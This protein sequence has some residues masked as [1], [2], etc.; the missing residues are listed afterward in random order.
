M[1]SINYWSTLTLSL[2][3]YRFLV[4]SESKPLVIKQPIISVTQCYESLTAKNIPHLA[5]RT[6]Q[7]SDL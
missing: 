3:C 7:L 6:Y 5:Y 4:V 2:M 1:T